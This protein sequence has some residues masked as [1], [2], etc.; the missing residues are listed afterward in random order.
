MNGNKEL[1]IIEA[2]VNQVQILFYSNSESEN[3]FI[4]SFQI[5]SRIKTPTNQKL[6]T[7]VAVV[8]MKKGGKRFEIGKH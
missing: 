2:I 8:R 6:L 3:F 4:S 5:M 1:N 7:N